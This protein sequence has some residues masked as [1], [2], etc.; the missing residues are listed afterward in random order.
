[1]HNTKSRAPVT[2]RVSPVLNVKINQYVRIVYGRTGVKYTV[3]PRHARA[4]VE[5]GF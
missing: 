2:S 1:M 3:F 4:L 5:R